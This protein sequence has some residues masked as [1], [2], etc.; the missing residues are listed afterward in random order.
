MGNHQSRA[1]CRSV[2]ASG[3]NSPVVELKRFHVLPNEERPDL[4]IYISNTGRWV[5]EDSNGAMPLSDGDIL[6]NGTKLW[7]FFDVGPVDA[8]VEDDDHGRLVQAKIDFHFYISLDE[9]H[10]FLKLLMDNALLDDLG[11]RVHHYLLL[12]LARQRLRDARDGDDPS[13]QGWVEVDRLASMLR[14]EPAHLNIQIYR[15]RKQVHSALSEKFH[16]PEIIER[17]VGAHA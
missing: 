12:L 4:S 8:T 10:V 2:G 9:E 3:E 17:R 13:A 14:I 5:Y 15:A 11:E 7:Q 6:R 1:S 16:L